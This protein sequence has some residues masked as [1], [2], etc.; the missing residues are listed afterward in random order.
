[1]IVCKGDNSL[2]TKLSEGV[3]E[4]LL[5]LRESEGEQVKEVLGIMRSGKEVHGRK[6]R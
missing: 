1:V 6:W 4:K 5:F 2:T 3:M